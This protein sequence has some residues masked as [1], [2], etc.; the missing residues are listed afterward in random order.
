MLHVSGA[1][2]SDLLTL[3]HLFVYLPALKIDIITILGVKI[4]A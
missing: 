1:G 4:E 3:S 2:L